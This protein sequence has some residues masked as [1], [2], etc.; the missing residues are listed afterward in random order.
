M[1]LKKKRNTI[2]ACDEYG[3]FGNIADTVDKCLP[4]ESNDSKYHMWARAKQ[5]A[6]NRT[7]N[8]I[9]CELFYLSIVF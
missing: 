9:L 3:W 7:T 8:L 1:M 5:E 6:T 2:R 4:S